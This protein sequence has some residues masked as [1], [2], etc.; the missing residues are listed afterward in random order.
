MTSSGPH[1]MTIGN[2]QSRAILMEVRRLCGHEAIGPSA[3]FDQSISR[4]SLSI[5]PPPERKFL[6]PA[7]FIST[8]TFPKVFGHNLYLDREQALLFRPYRRSRTVFQERTVLAL[9]LQAPLFPRRK[10]ENRSGRSRN[11]DHSNNNSRGP[12]QGVFN[13]AV[14]SRYKLLVRSCDFERREFERRRGG[15]S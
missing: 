4:M 6:S 9:P 2:A 15:V 5:S 12:F 13:A 14:L 3:V 1:Q 11:L 8:S 10:R 7:D